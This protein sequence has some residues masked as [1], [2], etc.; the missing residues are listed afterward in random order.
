MGNTVSASDYCLFC[1]R[2]IQSI[3]TTLLSRIPS[4]IP[5]YCGTE[6]QTAGFKEHWQH[7]MNTTSRPSFTP[8]LIHLGQLLKYKETRK[9]TLPKTYCSHDE[10]CVSCKELYK[11]HRIGA[12]QDRIEH[13]IDLAI[14]YLFGIGVPKSSI[15]A[16]VWFGKAAATGNV[17]A[18]QSLK[19]MFQK[20]EAICKLD[21]VLDEEAE[22]AEEV[23]PTD[24]R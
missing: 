9:L 1:R 16:A 14:C 18:I 5:A 8:I 22:E 4:G 10:T 21:S 3:D 24:P 6:C 19:T 23:E 11:W 2:P 15:E 12:E 7:I 13:Q 17:F 20:L